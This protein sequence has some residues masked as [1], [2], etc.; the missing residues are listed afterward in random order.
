M[1]TPL[2]VG[3]HGCMRIGVWRYLGLAIEKS[4]TFLFV[5]SQ[6]EKIYVKIIA[7][8]KDRTFYV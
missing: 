5:V 2:G 4:N 1:L 6:K 7:L 8:Q 3:F